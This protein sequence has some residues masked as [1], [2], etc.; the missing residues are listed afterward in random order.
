MPKKNIPL[1][2]TIVPIKYTNR[3]FSTIKQGLI[4]HAKRYY[5]DT[6]ADFNEAGFG[7][8]MLDTVAY[9]GDILSYYL[10]YQ[11]NES[12]LDTAIEYN[13]VIRHGKQLGYKFQASPSSFGDVDLYIEVP[14]SEEETGPDTSYAMILQRGTKVSSL[15]G[16]MFTLAADVDFS[17]PTNEVVVATV[18]EDT[19]APLTYA[20][21]A[22]GQ[23][24]SGEIRSSILTIGEFKRFRRIRIPTLDISEI[25]SVV[26]DEGNSY[27]EVDY[28]SQ[29]VVYTSV[30]NYSSDMSNAV[31][32]IKPIAVPRRFVVD[33]LRRE[34]FLQFGYGSETEL[35]Q[36]SVVDPTNISL[37]MNGKDYITDQSFDPNKMLNDDKFGIGP[38][39]TNL[40]IIYRV[41]TSQ[42][43]NAPVGSLNTVV[44]PNYRFKDEDSLNLS[45]KNNT[46]LSLE[47]INPKP[48]VGSVDYPSS[49]ELKTRVMDNFANQ[50]RAVTVQDYKSITYAMPK[51]F[52]EIY[53]A[54]IERDTD[55]FKRNL[56]LYVISKNGSGNLTATSPTIKNNLK[57][58]LLK[59]KML[60][61][62]IDIL[63]AQVINLGIEFEI[64]SNPE[65]TKETALNRAIIAIA[66]QIQRA[67]FEIGQN[68]YITDLYSSLKLAPGILDVLRM[69]VVQKSGPLYSNIFF[70]VENN[71]SADGRYII[72]PR[73]AIF[74]IRNP[75]NDIVGTVK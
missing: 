15:A 65:T 11:A 51:N 33:T 5:P 32:I 64:M 29:N 68:F 22:T 2:N 3:E 45:L 60:N 24:Q 46:V 57:T 4:E 42:N 58:W 23:V 62:T 48:I 66:A 54:H 7:S 6:F 8:L 17:D 31:N 36:P 59:N 73:N 19:G 40:T 16:N 18:D 21:R 43:M 10:D 74:E 56:N 25:I 1:N 53:R 52:G 67:S 13:N 27:Y 14:A 61:D 26:D 75:F 9:V 20:I 69:K 34:T 37:K 50:N 28:L 12:F 49:E 63:D 72:C 71:T 30:G 70:D 55:S 41:N 39:N 47:V 35:S 38:E 44:S